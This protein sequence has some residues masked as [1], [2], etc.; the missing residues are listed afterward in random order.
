VQFAV[1]FLATDLADVT[2]LIAHRLPE[3]RREARAWPRDPG[4]VPVGQHGRPECHS[5]CRACNARATRV[6]QRAAPASALRSAQGRSERFRSRVRFRQP[7]RPSARV[8]NRTCNGP[9]VLAHASALLSSS[10]EGATAYLDADLRDPGKILREAGQLLD[11][12]QPVAVLVVG[13]LHL[14]PGAEQPY[15]IVAQ[16]LDAVPAG[17]YLVINHPASDV[18]AEIV[19]E[20]A[21]RYNQSASAPQTRRSHAEVS[22]SFDGLDLLSP[23]VVQTHRWRPAPAGP[24]PA[25][26]DP[27]DHVSA[28]CGVGRK[29]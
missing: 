19:A 20:G 25:G 7:D 2:M 26:P 3:L 17:S 23:G 4:R 12:G 27:A 24:D 21:R 13:I 6:Q 22:R 16:L 29:P 18:N 10:A 28:W 14:I 8:H 15:S 1:T 11:L 5:G 9:I